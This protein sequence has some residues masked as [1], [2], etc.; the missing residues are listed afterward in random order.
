MHLNSELLFKKYA[1][2]VFKNKIKVLEIGPA[3]V[4][5][6]YQ[7]IVNNETIKWH[8]I[9]FESTTYI[10]AST[11]KLTYIINTPYTFPIEDEAYDIVLSGQ[12]IEHVS[13]PWL[14]L[15]ELKRVTKTN[16]T[17]ITINPVSWPYHEAPIDCWRIFPSGIEA[18]ADETGLEI[19]MCKFESLELDILKQ[20]CQKL[21]FVPGRSY[22]NAYDQKILA[23]R[24]RLEKITNKF[25]IINKYLSTPIEVAFDCI[26]ILKKH[27]E[28]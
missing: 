7:K 4:P 14:W 25:P 12:V 19:L 26:S 21:H 9:D 6:V 20:K 23:R 8:T 24:I 11:N 5:S 27:N 22:K 15:K 17:I 16:G 1:L 10:G 18:L 28:I 2:P 13:K 3:G